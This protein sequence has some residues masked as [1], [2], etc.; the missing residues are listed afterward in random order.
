VLGAKYFLRCGSVLPQLL[1]REF[2]FQNG[3][4]L[5]VLYSNRSSEIKWTQTLLLSLGA[6][7]NRYALLR[8]SNT[9]SL[10]VVRRCQ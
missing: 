1:A 10:Y 6:A 5:L 2:D 8:G 4:F 9:A 3:D 7:K